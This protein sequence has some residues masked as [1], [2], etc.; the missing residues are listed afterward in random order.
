MSLY[1]ITEDAEQDLQSNTFY[2]FERY[3][4]KQT[5]KYMEQLKNCAENMATGQGYFK[6]INDLIPNLRVKHCQ[7]HY[8]FGLMRD[9]HPMLVIAVFHE[10]MD[11]M[12][13]LDKRL[14]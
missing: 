10:K 12:V 2:T 6:E 8:I 7:H 3:G 13:Q 11:L 5:R 1:E 9:N 4:E 14:Q